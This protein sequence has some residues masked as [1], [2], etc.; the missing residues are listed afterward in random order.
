MPMKTLKVSKWGNSLAI[1]LPSDAVSRYGVMEGTLLDL[2]QMEQHMRLIP[3]KKRRITLK[4]IVDSI[5]P[6]DPPEYIDWGPPVGK[7]IW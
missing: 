2:S 6:N 3:Q 1:R 4:E 5:D 7:E